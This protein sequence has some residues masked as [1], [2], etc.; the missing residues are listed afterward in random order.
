MNDQ[1]Q[2]LSGGTLCFVTLS[3]LAAVGCGQDV[4]AADNSA[5]LVAVG[6]TSLICTQVD[7]GRAVNRQVVTAS[8]DA[9]GSL[10]N[11]TV[12][13]GPFRRVE[14]VAATSAA[15]PGY[16]NGYFE[17]TSHLMAWNIGSEGENDYFFLL[18]DTGILSGTFTAQLHVY[19]LHGDAGWWQKVMS[20]TLQ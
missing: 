18:P 19:F 17:Q 4:A 1:H 16:Q 10:A 2:R 15:V 5:A 11:V 6:G 7:P 14:H 8:I 20:C 13:R 12:L 9:S 3:V